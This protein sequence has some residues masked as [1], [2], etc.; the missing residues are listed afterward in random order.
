MSVNHF[1]PFDE[2]QVG[3]FVKMSGV[4]RDED[5]FIAV[6]ITVVPFSSKKVKLESLVQTIDAPN[7]RFRLLNQWVNV[8]KSTEIYR[9]NGET[10]SLDE[11]QPGTMV[12]VKG[13]YSPES[14]F[15]AKKI[16]VKETMEFNIEGLEGVIEQIDL[17]SHTLRVNGVK[18]QITPRTILLG[19][20]A[21][22]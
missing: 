15:R 21:L 20:E 10:G 19:E 4:S 3:Q 9:M 22:V 7:Q 16:R 2:L 11:L 17:S 6:E 18:I 12:K 14:G 1:I 13:H 8:E 5:T